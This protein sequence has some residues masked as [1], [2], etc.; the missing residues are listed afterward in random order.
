MAV[1]HHGPRS[2]ISPADMNI[3]PIIPFRRR[4]A[5]D[6]P[7][8]ESKYDGFRALADT[9]NGR[10]LSKNTNLMRRLG[11]RRNGSRF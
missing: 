7:A 1:R 8:F 10:I 5:F 6:D 4:E 11:R 9:M 2:G 3:V